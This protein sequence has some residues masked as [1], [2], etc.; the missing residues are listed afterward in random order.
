MSLRLSQ[1]DGR[2]TLTVPQRLHKAEAEAFVREKESWLRGHLDQREDDVPVRFGALLPVE[3]RPREILPGTGR[4]LRLGPDTLAVPGAAE[5]VPARVLAFLRERARAA[6]VAA[7]DEYAAR[8]GRPYARITLRDT[9][10][11]WG[12]CTAQG[13]LMYSWRLILTPPEILRYVA[14]HEVAHLAEMNHSA[15]FWDT[16]T[17]IHGPWK[18][19]RG[20]LREHGAGLHR[21]RFGD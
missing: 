11:R 5:Q 19:Q 21:F 10:S 16:V 4:A 3:G 18:A 15:A 12:S 9:R 20:W 8:L 13:A 6:L 17:A 14:A 2:I 1:L 7:S